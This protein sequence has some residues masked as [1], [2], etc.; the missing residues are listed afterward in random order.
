LLPEELLLN[1]K[2][3]FEIVDARME[4]P[5]FVVAKVCHPATDFSEASIAYLTSWVLLKKICGTTLE[6]PVN[7]D[8]IIRTRYP[9]IS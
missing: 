1:D 9:T 8:D 6:C 3:G 5:A 4:E 7:L 2:T